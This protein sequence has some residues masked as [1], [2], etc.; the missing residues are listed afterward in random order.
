MVFHYPFFIVILTVFINLNRIVLCSKKDFRNEKQFNRTLFVFGDVKTC[1]ANEFYD[2]NY[3]QCVAC[4]KI[5]D[6][7]QI[8]KESKGRII[9]RFIEVK[10]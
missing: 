4:Q 8:A 6:N 9:F 7:L 5:G 10:K 3:F 1:A 2:L